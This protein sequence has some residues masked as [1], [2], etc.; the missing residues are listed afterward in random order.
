MKFQFPPWRFHLRVA[1][2]TMKIESTTVE[3]QNLNQLRLE[4]RR[5][6]ACLIVAYSLFQA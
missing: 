1:D 4:T 6:T 5:S 3:K 2:I